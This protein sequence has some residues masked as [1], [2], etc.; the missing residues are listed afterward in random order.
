MGPKAKQPE[1]GKLFERELEGV[2]NMDHPLVKLSDLIDWSEFEES[3]SGL[4]PS[5]RGRPATS[6]RLIAGLLYLQHMQ[7]CSDE[8]LLWTWVENPYMQYFCGMT[9]FQ[10][11]LP[12]DP[13]SLTRWRK[14]LG[15]RGV[16]KLLEQTIEAAKKGRVIKERSLERVIVDSTVM[17]KAV[18][19]PTDSRLLSADGN[20]W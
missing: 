5:K 16:E 4:F 17:E 15:E 1:S 2:I 14:R 13:S 11:R 10:H 6:T 8:E 9:H 19:F 3:W 7:G 12:I 18:A 20:I